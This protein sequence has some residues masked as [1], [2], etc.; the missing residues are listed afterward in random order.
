MTTSDKHDYLDLRNCH[1]YNKVGSYVLSNA[2]KEM[3]CPPILLSEVIRH[4]RKKPRNKHEKSRSMS[5]RPGNEED[6]IGSHL[7]N[8]YPK[9][10]GTPELERSLNEAALW[11]RI[12]RKNIGTLNMLLVAVLGPPTEEESEEL[13]KKIYIRYH[14]PDPAPGEPYMPGP[15]HPYFQAHDPRR[16]RKPLTKFHRFMKVVCCG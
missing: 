8:D 10:G 3:S 7:Q 11:T 16:D 15:G 6:R 1:I 12:P 14:L 5:N 13:W 2:Q 9:H 4:A